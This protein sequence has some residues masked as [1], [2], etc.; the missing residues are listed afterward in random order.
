MERYLR[1]LQVGKTYVF[2]NGLLRVRNDDEN[3]VL[4]GEDSIIQE[5]GSQD[6]DLQEFTSIP[7]EE[8]QSELNEERGR[9]KSQE[10]NKDEPIYD[11]LMRCLNEI[12][13]IKEKM[14]SAKLEQ[15]IV[16]K[17]SENVGKSGKAELM[18]FEGRVI[19]SY[20]IGKH[21][22]TSGMGYK[23]EMLND[24]DRTHEV[25][26]WDEAKPDF[27]LIKGK[28]YRFRSFRIR[29]KNPYGM[30][31]YSHYEHSTVERLD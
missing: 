6:L 8:E 21:K 28:A 3:Y 17:Q 9:Q 14:T 7:K 20:Q 5:Q 4:M 1:I 29:S 11:K 25:V 31:L 26:I 10:E 24:P 30:S 22:A 18:D 12:T 16:P 2:R 15:A 27:N 23:V 19:A 13:E